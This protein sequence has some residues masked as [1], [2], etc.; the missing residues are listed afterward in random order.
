MRYP[1]SV[2]SLRF[3]IGIDMQHSLGNHAP[4]LAV[5]LGVQQPHIRGDAFIVIWGQVGLAWRFV[6]DL[7]IRKRADHYAAFFGYSMTLAGK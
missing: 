4:I 3:L 6:R 2:R 5:V 7:W 1:G